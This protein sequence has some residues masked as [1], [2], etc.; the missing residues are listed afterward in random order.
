MSSDRINYTVVREKNEGSFASEFESVINKGSF[1]D[2][3]GR[4]DMAEM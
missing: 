4:G 2:R 1:D 3:H